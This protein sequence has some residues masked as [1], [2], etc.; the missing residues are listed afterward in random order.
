[1][2]DLVTGHVER[3][4]AAGRAQI[5]CGTA[6]NQTSMPACADVA[7]ECLGVLARQCAGPAQQPRIGIRVSLGHAAEH[8]A[9]AR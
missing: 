1:M 6:L 7:R 3:E 8:G 9:S 4:A 5:R 2:R